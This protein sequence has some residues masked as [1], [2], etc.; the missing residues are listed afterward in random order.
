MIAKWHSIGVQLGIDQ[1][2]LE[3][4]ESNFRTANRR[5]SEVINFW[6]RGN[7]SDSVAVS[8]KSLVEILEKPFIGE[9]G[10]AMRLRKKIGMIVSKTM[11]VPE[12]E[13]Q[14][15]EINGG[16]RGKKRTT[17]QKLD[18]SGDQHHE[19]QGAYVC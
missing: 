9:K 3:E 17:E 16:R 6:L 15:L 11:D 7:T 4:I 1:A 19:H 12:S 14:P 10:L 5:F 8:W 18:D 13:V 2:K